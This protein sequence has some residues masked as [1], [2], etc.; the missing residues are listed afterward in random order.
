MQRAVNLPPARASSTRTRPRVGASSC[1]R[2]RLTARLT[3]RSSGAQHGHLCVR[4]V[5]AAI[6]SVTTASLECA[7]TTSPPP[8]RPGV[9]SLSLS[10][11]RAQLH[12][13]AAYFPDAPTPS[14]SA[15]A[16][17]L[18]D[19]VAILYPCAHCREGFAE[20]CAA[21][22]PDVSSRRS[23]AAWLCAAHNAVNEKLGKPAFT[24]DDEKL[25]LRWRALS[26]ACN[27]ERGDAIVN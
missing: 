17:A 20:T 25:H 9:F 8:E 18:V 24:C 6:R 2:A 12:T 3:A 13:T 1:L 26:A 21:M 16:R 22:P 14:E 7:L 15:A 23:F 27:A 11:A 5:C 19:A 4:Y 10:L